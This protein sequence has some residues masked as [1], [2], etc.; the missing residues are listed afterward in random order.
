MKVLA[1]D[2]AT[3]ACSVAVTR[4]DAVLARRDAVQ[5]RGQAEIL[6]PMVEA[7]LSEAG[8]GYADL[9]RLAV[10]VGPGT[11]TGIRIALATAR[12]LALAT[13]RPLLGVTTFE[14]LAHAV[15]PGLLAGRTL[16]VAIDS[17]RAELYVQAFGPDLVPLG[18]PVMDLPG[19]IP[20]PPGPLL[21]VGDA[22]AAL[23]SAAGPRAEV[24]G[25]VRNPDAAVVARLAARRPLPDA[26]P[27]PLYLRAPDVTL[28]SREGPKRNATG[29]KDPAP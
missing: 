29:A 23:A 2:S 26:A 13:G 14:A 21:L 8:L 28:P 15:A 16:V 27:S 18:A 19:A 25:Q 22:A 1:L 9:D 5:D 6:V 20:L 10:T 3:G 4:R 7:A 17:R 24:A 11:F 12:G